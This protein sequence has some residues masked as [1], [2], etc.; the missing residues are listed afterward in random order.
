MRDLLEL[1]RA[2][3]REIHNP[4]KECAQKHFTAN[5]FEAY[6]AEDMLKTLAIRTEVFDN[7]EAKRV[8]AQVQSAVEAQCPELLVGPAAWS[9]QSRYLICANGSPW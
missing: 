3:A 8:P 6:N 4:E 2:D 7:P 9:G 5:M 1:T